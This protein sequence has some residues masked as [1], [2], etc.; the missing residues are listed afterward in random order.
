MMG[1]VFE[2][3]DTVPMENWIGL[4]FPYRPALAS[5]TVFSLIQTSSTVSIISIAKKQ[6]H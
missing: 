1:D 5:F 3:R 4:S 6:G 2:L